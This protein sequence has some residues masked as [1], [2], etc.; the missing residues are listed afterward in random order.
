MGAG[1]GIRGVWL[2]HGGGVCQR[3]VRRQSRGGRRGGRGGTSQ[4]RGRRGRGGWR[5]KVEL[6]V[7]RKRLSEGTRKRRSLE[8]TSRH[9]RHR[10]QNGPLRRSVRPARHNGSSARAGARTGLAP[11]CA[12]GP[13]R[14]VGGSAAA[15]R[16]WRCVSLPSRRGL[17]AWL[18]PDGVGRRHPC[19]HE[20]TQLYGGL[21]RSARGLRPERGTT[22]LRGARFWRGGR[23]RGVRG[24]AY[25]AVLARVQL[26]PDR[27]W[28][29]A[30][31]LLALLRAVTRYEPTGGALRCRALQ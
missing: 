26:F 17:T 18:G 27:G 23:R 9:N 6:A 1:A 28:L 7:P 13:V 21:S 4:G 14:R 30:S 5:K 31:L 2:G 15:E 12:W 20:N 11:R 3:V 29:G 16:R 25:R 10:N 8:C 24:G 19:G 22:D